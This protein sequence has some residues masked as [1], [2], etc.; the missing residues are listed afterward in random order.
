[1]ANRKHYDLRQMVAGGYT[2]DHSSIHKFGAVPQMSINNT[3]TVWDI[4]DTLYP[5][6]ALDTP[7]VVNI[8][9]NSADDD[10][11]DVI[12]EGLDSDWNAQ[13]ETITIDGADTVGTKLFRRVNRAFIETGSASTNTGNIDIEAGAAGGTTVARITAGQGQTLMAVY[14]IPAGYIGYVFQG[15][16][17]IQSGGDATGFM[18]VRKNTTGTAFRVAHT[19]ELAGDGGQYFYPFAF[20]VP[21]LEKSDIDIRASVRSNN[22]RVTAAFDLLLVENRPEA[23]ITASL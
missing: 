14:T 21:L 2:T 3:G 10:G 9:R 22:A 13:T 12:V 6:S 16:A 8:E 4:N 20:P 18:Y 7:A 17:S 19:F 23:P 15:T 5:W 1:M 11:F